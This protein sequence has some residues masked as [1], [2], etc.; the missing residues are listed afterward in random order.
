[1]KTC[2]QVRGA[3]ASLY[4]APV[5]HL[6]KCLTVL[7]PKRFYS[8]AYREKRWDGK[9]RLY[10]DRQFPAGL[11]RRV[12]E[13]LEKEGIDVAV[14]GY[15]DEGTPVDPE[16]MVLGYCPVPGPGDRMFDEMWEHQLG[17]CQAIL[18]N[19]RG[20]IKSPTASGKS[21]MVAAT[22][23]YFWEEKEW[24]SL[25]IVPKKG[26]L[27]QTANYFKRCYGDALEVGVCGDG[28]R[29]FG[30]V[31]VGTAQTL[32]GFRPRRLRRKDKKTG[33]VRYQTI[34]ADKELRD[35]IKT[36]DVL[37]LDECHHSSSDSWSEIAMYCGAH[38]RYGLSGTPLKNSEI[39]DLKM[40]GATGPIIYDVGVE[41]LM[42]VGLAARPKIAMVMSDE[43]SE[44]ELPYTWETRE[45]NHG[46]PRKRRVDLPYREAYDRGV[47][48]SDRH[49]AAVVRAVCW[50]VEH[51]RQT[52]ILCRRKAQFT[53]LAD[54][55][56][57]GGLEFR[58]IWGSTVTPE[59]ER[60]KKL[61]NTGKISVLLATVILDEGE[62]IER[63]EGLV[64]AEG[65]KV[66]TNVIQRI[67]RGMRKKHHQEAN[68]VWV[69]DFCPTCHPKLMEHARDRCVAYE[70]EGHEVVVVD[71]WPAPGDTEFDDTHLLPF[72]RWE[73]VK[74]EEDGDGE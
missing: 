32:I 6:E 60:A 3:W 54:M 21:F 59:R 46:V 37:Y 39:A 24:T 42:S 31:T 5:S 30:T 34:P 28:L 66:A 49:N 9:V 74:E 72:E 65:V 7:D 2:I 57:D 16:R 22:A 44:Q 1:M 33:R 52:L 27:H 51:G 53:K 40:I 35:L 36:T 70:A 45:D 20:V 29:T 38:R 73:E 56:E 15:G 55:L 13:H 64:L 10:S 12:L 11:V 71:E 19:K 62:D 26:L 4:G 23:R 47:V 68:D 63:V 17:A 50:L 18:R 67:G 58:A 69:V 14:I 41:R 25:V 61:L 43:A 48:E 8:R